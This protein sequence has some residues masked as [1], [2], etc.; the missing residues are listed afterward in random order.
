[1]PSSV[2]P[3]LIPNNARWRDPKRGAWLLSLLVPLSVAAGPLLW[4]RHPATVMLWLPVVFLYLVAPLLD[5]VMGTDAANPPESAVPALDAD[6]YYRWITFALV[7]L[8]WGAFIYATWFSQTAVLSWAGQL[9][10]VMATGG[11]GGFCINIGHEI[12]HKRARL[13]RWLARLI[14]APTGYTHFTIEHNIGHHRDVATPADSASSRMGESIWHFVLRE[15]PGA[16]RRAWSLECGR[17]NRTRKTVWSIHNEILQG[18][19]V[20]LVLWTTLCAWLGPQALLFI[21]PTALWANFQLTS[22]NYI[23]HYGLLRQRGPDGGFQRCQPRHSW[24]SNHKFSNWATFHLQRHSDHHAHPL[25]RYQS[26][27][28]FDEAPQLPS[29][30][31]GMFTLAYVPPLW[32]AVMDPRLVQAVGRDATR[33]HFAPGQRKRLSKRYAL[34]EPHAGVL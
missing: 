17:L 22:A 7:P 12:G 10:L 24:N 18:A 9:G 19:A 5:L 29:G 27:R 26:L 4:Q 32:F 2:P 14:L 33:I 6:L 34:A 16:W 8:L 15:M 3:I 1:M 31:F 30:Y 11:V 20:T 25:R 28:H 23:E 13:E 21:L